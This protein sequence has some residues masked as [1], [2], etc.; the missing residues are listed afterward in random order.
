MDPEYHSTD[1]ALKAT[2]SLNHG[3]FAR[4]HLYETR[5]SSEDDSVGLVTA[6]ARAGQ[7]RAIL[8]KLTQL[9]RDLLVLRHAPDHLPCSCGAPCCS[10]RMPNPEWSD[11]LRSVAHTFAAPLAKGAMGSGLLR[12][13]LLKATIRREHIEYK[14]VAERYEI[15]RRTVATH[16]ATLHAAIWG[17]KHSAGEYQR[18]FER[19]DALLREAGIVG[20]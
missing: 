10:G 4:L 15:D 2:Y 1:A 11:A 19:A 7:I 18:A 12:A 9:D 17:T 3:R 6:A 8:Q 20:D 5:R 13:E 14:E 16:A